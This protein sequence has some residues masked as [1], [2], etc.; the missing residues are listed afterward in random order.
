MNSY[1][2]MT[3]LSLEIIRIFTNEGNREFEK[4][5][6]KLINSQKNEIGKNSIRIKI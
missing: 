4:I 2:A 1:L 5:K 6:D 3:S